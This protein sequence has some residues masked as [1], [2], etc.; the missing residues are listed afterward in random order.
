MI[1]TVN[2]HS[3]AVKCLTAA[4]LALT[5]VVGGS[6]DPEVDMGARDWHSEGTGGS[7]LSTFIVQQRAI[8]QGRDR[9]P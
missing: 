1:T 8:T 4:M 2:V 9:R 7:L 6:P 3:E 5:I